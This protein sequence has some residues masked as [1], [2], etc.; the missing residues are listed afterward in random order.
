MT[1]AEQKFLTVESILD[2]FTPDRRAERVIRIMLGRLSLRELTDLFTML[3][4]VTEGKHPAPV[5]RERVEVI[6]RKT[7]TEM[8]AMERRGE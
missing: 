3:E 6:L 1:E 5:L 2:L 7:A 4:A 8:R